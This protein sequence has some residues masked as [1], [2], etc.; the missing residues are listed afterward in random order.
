MSHTDSDT[1]SQALPSLRNVSSPALPPREGTRR[2][3]GRNAFPELSGSAVPVRPRVITI[4][5]ARPSTRSYRHGDTPLPS[6]LDRFW[7]RP[8]DPLGSGRFWAVVGRG[9]EGR[10]VPV[11]P[12]A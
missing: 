5:R 1:R 10:T 6:A 4:I 3:H 8:G 7:L 9:D 11:A 12:A 2:N